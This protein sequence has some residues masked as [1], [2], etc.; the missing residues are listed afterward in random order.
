MTYNISEPLYK[1]IGIDEAI[2]Q[3]YQQCLNGLLIGRTINVISPGDFDRHIHKTVSRLLKIKEQ[4]K[5]QF[6]ARDFKISV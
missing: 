5:L 6:N 1:Q 2:A 3:P 4:Q